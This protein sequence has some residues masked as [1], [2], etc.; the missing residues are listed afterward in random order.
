MATMI[1]TTM[2]MMIS[3]MIPMMTT[4]PKLPTT[5]MPLLKVV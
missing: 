3:K 5:M 1:M 2:A 4:A